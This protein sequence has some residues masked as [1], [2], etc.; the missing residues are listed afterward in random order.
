[1]QIRYDSH[2]FSYALIGYSKDDTY[3]IG[4]CHPTVMDE[5]SAIEFAKDRLSKMVLSFAENLN[6]NC[7]QYAQAF[8]FLG[9]SP[10]LNLSYPSFK[11]HSTNIA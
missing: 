9:Q 3:I 7:D 5:S 1:V 10:H 8:L 4:Y 6:D 2:T 11:P